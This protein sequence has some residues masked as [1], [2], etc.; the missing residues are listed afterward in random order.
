ME[1]ATSGAPGKLLLQH[2]WYLLCYSNRT[3]CV[4]KIF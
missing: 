2:R 4:I 1:P 3:R